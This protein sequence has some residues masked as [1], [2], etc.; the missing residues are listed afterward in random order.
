MAKFKEN[1][2]CERCESLE[3][4]LGP[5]NSKAIGDGLPREP[6]KGVLNGHRQRITKIALHPTYSLLA[7]ASEDATIRL[8]DFEQGEHERTLKGHSGTVNCVTFSPNSG[9]TLASCSVDM[10]V[11]LW[12]MQTF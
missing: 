3:T 6:E 8:W 7:S 10:T 11:K 2:V 4:S 5:N 1:T 12:S 9:Q